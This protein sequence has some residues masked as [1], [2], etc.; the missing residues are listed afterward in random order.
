MATIT[1][2]PAR[3]HTACIRYIK[4]HEKFWKEMIDDK[5]DSLLFSTERNNKKI[6]LTIKSMSDYSLT[7]SINDQEFKLLEEYL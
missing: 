4:K 6:I 5:G 2:D 1:I 7:L 3:V